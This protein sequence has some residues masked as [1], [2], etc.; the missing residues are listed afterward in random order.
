MVVAALGK[1]MPHERPGAPAGASQKVACKA[2]LPAGIEFRA[3][4]CGR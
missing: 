2:N 1:G 3:A 4:P